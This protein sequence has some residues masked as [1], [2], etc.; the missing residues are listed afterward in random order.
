MASPFN[1]GAGITK[2]WLTD[3]WTPENRNAR[4]PR[5]SARNQYTAEN[6]SDSDF[7]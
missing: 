7:G 1:N 4:L 3:S 5:V 6:F 2:D